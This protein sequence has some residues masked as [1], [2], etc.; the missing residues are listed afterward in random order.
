MRV[1]S[2]AEV[3]PGPTK[4]S[5]YAG[6][7]RTIN[8]IGA[9]GVHQPGSQGFVVEVLTGGG[10]VRPHFHPM[11]QFQ[12]IA[13]GGGHL[14]KLPVQAMSFHYADCFTPY[15]PIVAGEEG[16]SFFTLRPKSS[17]GTYFVPQDRDKMERK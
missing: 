4:S 13:T 1:A 3:T 9:I 16:I 10:V 6:Q 2:H 14:G 11:R 12:V 17:V 7:V 5:E 8:Y 15:G